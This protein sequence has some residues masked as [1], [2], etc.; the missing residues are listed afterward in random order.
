MRQQTKTEEQL[1]TYT[2]GLGAVLSIIGLIILVLNYNP[3]Q[4]WS[5]FGVLV[6][7]SSMI[8]L[9]TTSMLYH[10]MR[11]VKRKHVFRVF[12]HISIYLLIA[13]T[14]TPFLLVAIQGVWGWTLLVII[15][16][17]A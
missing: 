17:L 12:D 8:I 11:D 3:E 9:F 4:K 6:Y 16:G 1:N 5:L 13:G 14:Y 15:W 10:A 7:G 2:H